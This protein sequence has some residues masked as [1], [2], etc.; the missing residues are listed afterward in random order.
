MVQPD[1]FEAFYAAHPSVPKTIVRKIYEWKVSRDPDIFPLYYDRSG[2]LGI[3]NFLVPETASASSTPP[4]TLNSSVMG[5]SVMP[6][7][8]KQEPI[9][10]TFR[11]RQS[12]PV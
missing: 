8:R 7:V 4:L 3:K 6:G 2:A 5:S 9:I 11:N 1:Q 10:L 12:R